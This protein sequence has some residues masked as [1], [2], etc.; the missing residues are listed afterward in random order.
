MKFR[1][2]SG[3]IRF[4][5]IFIVV[6][7]IAVFS[8]LGYYFSR[9][10]LTEEVE[11]NLSRLAANTGDDIQMILNEVSHSVDALST[12]VAAAYEM[13][14]GS[15]EAV[16]NN[17]HDLVDSL[18]LNL[19][20]KPISNV[21]AYV[22]LT[23]GEGSSAEIVY[24]SIALK[25]ENGVT[26]LDQQMRTEDIIDE[27]GWFRVPME[28]SRSFWSGIYESGIFGQEIITYSA[29]IIVD[30]QLVGIAA[31]D[32]QYSMISDILSSIQIFDNGY[33]YMVD[34]TYHSMYHPVIPRGTDLYEIN[35]GY[36]SPL[37][38]QMAEAENDTV[39]YGEG[40]SRSING[41]KR[42]DNGWVVGVAP[43]AREVF[44][45]LTQLLLIFSIGGLVILIV[46]VA[47]SFLAGLSIA[48]PISDVAQS[49]ER[50]TGYDLRDDQKSDRWQTRIDETGRIAKEI[51][52][53][54]ESLRNFMTNLNRNVDVLTTDAENLENATSETSMTLD[55]ISKTVEVL[56]DNA[57]AQNNNTK[58][59]VMKMNNLGHLIDEVLQGASVVAERSTKVSEFNETTD[60][61]VRDMRNS[62]QTTEKAIGQI[63]DRI[64]GLNDQSSAIE[65]VTVA[66]E[67][68]A[69]QTNLLALN[70]AIEAARAG[71]AGRGFAVVAEEVRKL[72]EET[73]ML[74]GRISE[75]MGMIQA[76]IQITSDDIELVNQAVVDNENTSKQM[77]DIFGQSTQSVR[78]IEEAI[79]TLN[80][81]LGMVDGDKEM[82]LKALGEIA[83]ITEQ[84][85]ASSQ[86]VYASV[87]EQNST[88]NT[89]SAMTQNMTE[90]AENLEKMTS[91]FTIE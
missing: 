20:V 37:L 55:Q 82:V 39:Y 89:I 62:L 41:F 88:L 73:A 85:A 44:R 43:L 83:E 15:H 59:S 28:E 10:L 18:V 48:N 14:D 79:G 90:V 9:D 80:E 74:T 69:D 32:M 34:E 45:P 42:L 49:V 29:P 16:N 36:I 4:A 64:N 7:L 87:E 86:E 46:G 66:I 24:S 40:R 70:A 3:R 2:I 67:Q 13:N 72:A 5:I 17:Y 53:M 57:A 25:E 61:A 77:L 51:S 8:S 63:N 52:G 22:L 31:M 58:E 81:A 6:L 30:G 76:D 84:N 26:L 38:D 19:A 23:E 50:I 12:S 47:I 21:D 35:G 27:T 33:A 56:A 71:D 54:R 75:T 91:Y 78:M 60:K 1:S 11:L 68:I 65:Q